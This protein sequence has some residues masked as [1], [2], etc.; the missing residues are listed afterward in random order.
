LL[1]AQIEKLK[2]GEF[3]EWMIEAVINDL[4][5]SQTRQYENNTALASAYYNAFIHR[6]HWTNK[7]AFLDELKNITK[8]ELVTFANAFYK[9]NYVVT[10][11]RRGEDEN[12]TKV[13]NPGITPVNL[14]RGKQSEFVQNFNKKESKEI[15][16]LF[17]DYNKELQKTTLENGVEVSYV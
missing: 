2:K 4:K 15:S 3:D 17:I 1:L 7:V 12:I 14:N 16:P 6:Q 11:K 5:L 10:Y 13:N 8:E 9:N